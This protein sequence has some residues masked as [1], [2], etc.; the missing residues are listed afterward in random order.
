MNNLSS[1]GN[2]ASTSVSKQQRVFKQSTDPTLDPKN[3]VKLNDIWMS[4]ESGNEFIKIRMN[5][6]WASAGSVYK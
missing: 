2:E 4:S 5:G 6:Y 3:K 1:T